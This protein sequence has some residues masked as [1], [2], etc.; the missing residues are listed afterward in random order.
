[1]R[2]LAAFISDIG[3]LRRKSLPFLTTIFE[4]WRRGK[5][6]EKDSPLANLIKTLTD[7][8]FTVKVRIKFLGEWDTVSAMGLP[9]PQLG[10]RAFS[11]VKDKVPSCVD[12][13]YHA[14]ALNERRSSFK[15]MLYT[16]ASEL[17]TIQQCAFLG[18]HADVGGGNEDVGLST[19]S[20]I[21]MIAGIRDACG[22]QF[23]DQVMLGVQPLIV[24]F[25]SNKDGILQGMRNW[26]TKSATTTTSQ[27][28]KTH[29]GTYTTIRSQGMIPP[30]NLASLMFL[31]MT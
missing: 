21:W 25:K 8:Q 18:C 13:A 23:D 31:N 7:A 2:C 29:T 27:A 3:L 17:T 19:I 9:V 20:L 16:K 11:F 14:V 10:D 22:A 26:F 15:P 12:Y 5:P 30:R 4:L 6:G 24:D 1:M 28:L